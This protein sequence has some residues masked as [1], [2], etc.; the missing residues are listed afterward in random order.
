MEQSEKISFKY[1]FRDYQKRA[2]EEIDK[3][4]NDNKIHIVAAPG[5][6][7]TILA[8]NLVFNLNEKTI[9]LVPTIAIREQWIERMIND[10]NNLDKNEI[11]TD[12]KDIKKY[13]V[14]TYQALYGYTKEEIKGIISKNKIKVIVM[15]EAH[16][17][18]NAW[19]KILTETFDKTKD[20]KTI[21][22][23]ATPPYDDQKNFEK[24]ID[25]CG[26]IDAEVPIPELVKKNNLCPHQDYIYFNYPTK[27]QEK[28]INSYRINSLKLIKSIENN[29]ELLKAI[30]LHR[31]I[32]DYKNNVDEIIENY[33]V[34][35]TMIKILKKNSVFVDREIRKIKNNYII[36]IKEYEN[37]LKYLLYSKD[38]EFKIIDEYL[39]TIKNELYEIGAIEDKNINLLYNKKI[40][41]EIS[42]NI[43]KLESIND[44]IDFEYKCLENKLKMVVVTDYIK[45]DTIDEELNTDNQIGA[46]PIFKSIKNNLNNKLKLIVLTGTTVIIPSSSL[47]N[48][49]QICFQNKIKEEDI[50]LQEID[51]D[52]EY[53][54]VKI[55]KDTLMVKIITELFEKE[56]ISVLIGTVA[57]I[58]EGWDAPYVNT[59]VIASGI[60]TYVTSNQLRGRA[61]RT[62]KNNPSKISNIWHIA[63][64]EKVGKKYVKGK[65][66][67]KIEKRFNNIEGLCLLE[68]KLRSGFDRF[69]LN[70][71]S[72]TESEIIEEN[73]L[74]KK[75]AKNREKIKES[76][77]IALNNYVP[78]N[79]Y[80]VKNNGIIKSAKLIHKSNTKKYLGMTLID[81]FTAYNVILNPAL[82]PIGSIIGLLNIPVLINSM[83]KR[84]YN[85]KALKN[86]AKAICSALKN[87]KILDKKVSIKIENNNGNYEI[88]LINADTRSQNIFKKMLYEAI[89]K[90]IN[91]RYILLTGRYVF[92]I[93]S[94]FDTNKETAQKFLEIYKKEN[95]VLNAKVVFSKSA[96][97]KIE[98]L[99][100]M[101]EQEEINE[102]QAIFDSNVDIKW[103]SASLGINNNLRIE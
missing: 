54:K 49:K 32:I 22:L 90:K 28:E 19:W 94:I 4:I 58:G 99:K 71:N 31:F 65:D 61:I 96:K 80:I 53:C 9:I 29:S 38:E 88:F 1:E 16:H 10:F 57:L 62:N 44:I 15:D 97:G 95:K 3:Y 11:S 82:I 52:F 43:K 101:M 93:P 66:C 83:N 36:T 84:N 91:T 103:L 72:F 76:W 64:L 68:D 20:L 74:M 30:A 79:K 70:K 39:K 46:I 23:T 17:L 89:S 27:E 2:I 35:I 34:F 7:K 48:F 63:C 55:K 24:Y 41:N 25:L 47:E 12:L 92:N 77:N 37:L 50:S 6:G 18:R 5:A 56:N 45:E 85:K 86:I 51:I 59:L 26:E 73:D 14:I 81:L 69:N 21:A 98:K 60:S 78:I 40:E 33:E 42:Q 102:D 8:L 100:L 87:K 13:N 67:E 75:Q